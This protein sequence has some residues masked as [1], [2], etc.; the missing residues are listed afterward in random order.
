[1]ARLAVIAAKLAISAGLIWYA[2]SKI[3]TASALAE[4][5]ELTP[6]AAFGGLVLFFTQLGV[7]SSRLRELLAAL[8]RRLTMLASFDAVLI[9]AF[10]SQTL[11]SFVGGDAMRIWR[12]TGKKIPIGDAARAVLYDRVLG[13]VGMIVLIVAGLPVLFQVV[14]DKRVHAAILLLVGCAVAGCILLLSLHKLPA[15]WSRLRAFHFAAELSRMGHELLRI[16]ARM[17]LLLGLSVVIQVLNV[18]TIFV[19]AQGMGAQIDLMTCL[20]LVP[21]VLFLSMMPISFAGWGVRESAMIA[22]LSAVGVPASQSLAMSICYGLGLII[23]SLPGGML[24]LYTRK[25]HPS[26]PAVDQPSE[27]AP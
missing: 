3:D 20:A 21:P 25:P 17:L 19:F 6:L 13:F 16:P 8:D 9:G 4:I 27:R 10:F 1:M 22:A 12:I 26:P 2:F 15:T 14:Q 11:I 18:L 23:V 24:W 5:L 7:A